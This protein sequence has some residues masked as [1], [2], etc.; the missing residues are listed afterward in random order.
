MSA[1]DGHYGSADEAGGPKAA[2]ALGL[3]TYI[4]AINMRLVFALASAVLHHREVGVNAIEELIPLEIG[5]G[6]FLM[7]MWRALHSYVAPRI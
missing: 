6:I 5:C 7:T 3:N 2:A 1:V 4:G